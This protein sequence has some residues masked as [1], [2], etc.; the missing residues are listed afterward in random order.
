MTI[1][2]NGFVIEEK[3]L[4]DITN[5]IIDILSKKNITYAVAY[6]ILDKAKEELENTIFKK[7]V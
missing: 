7:C 2:I 1:N 5:Q 4:E 3:K 6:M